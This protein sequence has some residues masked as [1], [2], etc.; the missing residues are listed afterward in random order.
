MTDTAASAAGTWALGDRTVNRLGF[1]AMRL[2]GTGG[3]GQ[4]DDRDPEQSAAVVR[5]AVELGVNHLDTAGFYFSPTGRANEIIRAALAP[6]PHGLTIA[7][8]VG[9]GRDLTTGAWGDWATPVQLRTHVEH[10]LETLGL[11]RLHV[12]NYRSNGRDDVPAAVAALTALRDEGLL[13][14][15]GLS[16]V[17]VD[18]LA[19]S[20]KV[21]EIS[22]VQNRHAPGYER[23]D[24]DDVLAAC[25]ERGIAFVPFFTIAGQAREDAA[26]ERYDA[27]QSVA[28]AH[29]A[30]PAQVRIAWTLALG[31]HVLAIPGTGE[32][33][34]LEQNVAAASLR[35]TDK[36][37]HLL[38]ALE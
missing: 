8:K 4:G 28:D 26:R 29:D 12:V 20:T 13:E 1:G 32:L 22:C 31:P 16:N 2:T 15:I 23:A 18:A 14:H 34:H 37:R 7:T 17:G 25:L 38:A 3:M 24:S 30:T 9:P 11:D 33:S 10:N 19:A 27:V 5:R 36:E 6:Y 21:G 35:L